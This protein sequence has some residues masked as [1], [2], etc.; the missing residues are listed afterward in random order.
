MN[1]LKLAAACRDFIAHIRSMPDDSPKCRHLGLALNNRPGE[2]MIAALEEKTFDNK[3]IDLLHKIGFFFLDL[4]DGN[5]KETERFLRSMQIS[6]VKLEGEK[7]IISLRRP[8][9]LIGKKGTTVERLSKHLGMDIH[10]E[11][12]SEEYL[13]DYLIPQDWSGE[14]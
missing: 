12:D 1:A 4:Q 9:L 13:Y 11:E 14:F 8:G 2:Q 5:Y 7:V 10:I 3:T 6:Q